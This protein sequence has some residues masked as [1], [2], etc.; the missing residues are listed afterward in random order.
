MWINISK[1]LNE[2][3]TID[4]GVIVGAP[5]GTVRTRLR[6]ARQRLAAE[7]AGTD[8]PEAIATTLTRIDDWARGVR[9]QVFG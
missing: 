7:L 3:N 4:I 8:E 5:E 2:L 9:E 6:R 1:C